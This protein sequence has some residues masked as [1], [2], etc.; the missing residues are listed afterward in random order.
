VNV[1]PITLAVPHS[2]G[3]SSVALGA[4]RIRPGQ[5]HDEADAGWIVIRGLLR[6]HNDT[7][8][9]RSTPDGLSAARGLPTLRAYLVFLVTIDKLC[10]F[11]TLSAWS[12]NLP[13]NVETTISNHQGHWNDKNK[14]R[15]VDA[16]FKEIMVRHL[17]TF[18][19]LLLASQTMSQIFGPV[20]KFFFRAILWGAI[21][22]PLGRTGGRC[23]TGCRDGGKEEGLKANADYFSI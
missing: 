10:Y 7:P 15:E 6:G 1:T 9:G 18:T 5:F 8:C 12:W 17:Q 2:A 13:Q 19:M 3:N 21:P 22:F 23:P 4:P 11:L 20:L 16:K 14:M